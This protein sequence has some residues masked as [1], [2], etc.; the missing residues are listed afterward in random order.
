MKNHLSLYPVIKAGFHIDVQ[1][2]SPKA[3]ALLTTYTTRSCQSLWPMLPSS[4]CRCRWA[5]SLLPSVGW[6]SHP[7]GGRAQSEMFFWTGARGVLSQQPG[8][9]HEEMREFISPFRLI[10]SGEIWFKK[11][12]FAYFT[13]FASDLQ[14]DAVL[15]FSQVECL[16]NHT[17]VLTVRKRTCGVNYH[18]TRA[19]CLDARPAGET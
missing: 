1:V 18:T 5:Q 6:P 14:M 9:G 11:R 7:V 2:N 10:V 4:A 15:V 3:V 13:V 17:L 19:W 16:L 12:N 8:C